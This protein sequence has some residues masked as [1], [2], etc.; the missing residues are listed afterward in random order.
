MLS[1]DD[2]SSLLCLRLLGSLQVRLHG[3]P[4]RPLRTRKGLW[5]LALL[6]LRAN[7]DVPREWLPGPPRPDHEQSQAMA[8]LRQP[9]PDLRNALGPEASRLRSPNA[10]AL[11]LSLG[12]SEADVL[13]F[14]AA[15]ACG[16][17][18]SLEAAVSLY[19]GPLLEGWVEE[20]V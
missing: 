16:D 1:A 12:E 19:R 18:A 20:W 15:I 3:K 8:S 4:L 9:L 6:T 7:R 13:A 14:D 11:T 2:S 17:K 5:L 10:H